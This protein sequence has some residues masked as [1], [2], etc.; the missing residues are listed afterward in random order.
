MISKKSIK[1]YFLSNLLLQFALSIA[2]QNFAQAAK[3]LGADIL[4]SESQQE[5]VGHHGIFNMV[6]LSSFTREYVQNFRADLV[7]QALPQ[8]LQKQVS[9][10]LFDINNNSKLPSA[11]QFH[12]VPKN[13]MGPLSPQ[14]NI[15]Y[16]ELRNFQLGWVPRLL[17]VKDPEI[18]GIVLTK[19]IKEFEKALQEQSFSTKK[20][21]IAFLDII[22]V[23]FYLHLSLALEK[24]NKL[25]KF[26]K[27]QTQIISLMRDPLVSEHFLRTMGKYLDADSYEASRAAKH[28]YANIE[29]LD[30][31]YW[32]KVKRRM[33]TSSFQEKV[34]ANNALVELKN[35]IALYSFNLND[36]IDYMNRI[37]RRIDIADQ[38]L[39][40]EYFERIMLNSFKVANEEYLPVKLHYWNPTDS[41][42][43]AK[44]FQSMLVVAKEKDLEASRK[45]RESHK[46]EEYL[47]KY[48]IEIMKQQ[49]SWFSRLLYV[50]DAEKFKIVVR[51]LARNLESVL[52]LAEE[53]NINYP[54][55]LSPS[56]ISAELFFHIKYALE[57]T[58]GGRGLQDEFAILLDTLKQPRVLKLFMS[59]FGSYLIDSSGEATIVAQKIFDVLD[60]QDRDLWLKQTQ[61]ADGKE[62]SHALKAIRFWKTR[63]PKIFAE[64]MKKD[65]WFQESLFNTNQ[66]FQAASYIKTFPEL[67]Q[68]SV[69]L[70]LQRIGNQRK[71]VRI[72][73]FSLDA[74]NFEEQ[75]G[76][77]FDVYNALYKILGGPSAIDNLIEKIQKSTEGTEEYRILVQSPE[78]QVLVNLYDRYGLSLRTIKKAKKIE[79]D[80]NLKGLAYIVE[81]SRNASR[82]LEFLHRMQMY[83]G[84]ER[85]Q[86][87]IRDIFEESLIL[88][89]EFPEFFA[90]SSESK[91]IT[92]RDRVRRT[93]FLYLA[94]RE[95]IGIEDI[96]LIVRD[97]LS[98]YDWIR[99][100]N[101]ES[102]N[103]LER[104]FSFSVQKI[105]NVLSQHSYIG[106]EGLARYLYER[107][108][109]ALTRESI[110]YIDSLV[111]KQQSK[112]LD[113]LMKSL[114]RNHSKSFLSLIQTNKGLTS[115]SGFD[116]LIIFGL[117][118]P[119]LVDESNK[120]LN[121]DESNKK[122]THVI[123]DPKIFEAFLL[124]SAELGRR[125]IIHPSQY[126]KPQRNYILSN[127]CRDLFKNKI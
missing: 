25:E 83:F 9:G 36:E 121:Y 104:E 31:G 116:L 71:S 84:T 1:F 3:D 102:G 80:E 88:K 26:N 85:I 43:D 57:R 99:T 124:K 107:H 6:P 49:V 96:D 58:V 60:A 62:S 119:V 103:F 66:R 2:L 94:S 8:A 113:V 53:Q 118:K 32:I 67:I 23:E 5:L 105:L 50:Q 97:M 59:S 64:L 52:K 63:D 112:A 95:L 7:T 17:Y 35:N 16:T 70:T 34:I 22:G 12:K 87:I 13:F 101:L 33:Q 55:I 92:T 28:L 15:T 42:D 18:F 77:L 79:F 127:S 126:K 72:E 73:H 74:K 86:R 54:L 19:L 11:L 21:K 75:H 82:D 98:G 108:D 24:C 56:Q 61:V 39:S 109:L 48:R 125:S 44:I 47:N 111:L 68:L 89:T 27:Y 51:V 120:K 78:Y 45:N 20:E 10:L 46:L 14:Q 91:L 37:R 114:Q 90:S 41:I 29:F 4:Q 81:I 30:P 115:L 38:A 123:S 76:I 100:L 65:R 40:G 93:A 117:V 106:G 122:V 69:L 110:G